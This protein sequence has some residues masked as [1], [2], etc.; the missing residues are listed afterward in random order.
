LNFKLQGLAQSADEIA[1]RNVLKPGY[2][3]DLPEID[4]PRIGRPKP[5]GGTGGRDP[6]EDVIEDRR[7]AE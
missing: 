7:E 2:E 1:A 5:I 3:G 6:D 4:E